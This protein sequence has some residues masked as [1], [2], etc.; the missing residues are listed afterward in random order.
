MKARNGVKYNYVWFRTRLEAYGIPSRLV[1][2]PHQVDDI[3]SRG[4]E[5]D[6]HPG[7]IDRNERGEK[8]KISRAKHGEV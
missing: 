8:I 2:E 6:L 4:D 1:L 7:V 3:G 5:K